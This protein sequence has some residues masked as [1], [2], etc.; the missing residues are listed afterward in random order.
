MGKA[1]L[2]LFTGCCLLAATG[3]G[4]GMANVSN[5][6]SAYVVRS[7]FLGTSMYYCTAESGKPVCT[8]VSEN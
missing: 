2:L 6:K 5:E 1:L 8:K 3:C 4:A 7:G